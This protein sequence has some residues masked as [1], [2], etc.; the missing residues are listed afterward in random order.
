MAG[1]RVLG[2]NHTSFTVSSLDSAI[3]FFSDVL[4]F[5]QTSR[6][7]RAPQLIQTLSGIAGA[8]IEVAYLQAPGHAIELIEYKGPADR[9]RVEARVCDVGA[10]HIAFDVD[11]VDA[12]VAAAARYDVRPMGGTL[13]IGAGPN[14]GGKAAYLR[15]PDGIFMEFIQPGPGAG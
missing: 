10:A 13:V 2:T 4:G 6:A 11:D 14:K 5:R 7:P 8:D 1:Y 9:G 3:A 15:H 12:A